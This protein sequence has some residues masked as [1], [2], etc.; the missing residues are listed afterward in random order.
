MYAGEGMLLWGTATE[1]KSMEE[2]KEG[3]S[4]ERHILCPVPRGNRKS[5]KWITS[6]SWYSSCRL[7]R[8]QCCLMLHQMCG[9]LTWNVALHQC[10]HWICSATERLCTQKRLT[11][12][13][14]QYPIM[15]LLCNVKKIVFRSHRVS[16]A[17]ALTVQYRQLKNAAGTSLV[18]TSCQRA[19]SLA[20]SQMSK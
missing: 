9:E 12:L 17:R 10:V 1:H 15:Y 18:Y 13:T 16:E 4:S 19:S 8:G 2:Y 5:N 3:M 11:E 7:N 14:A 20:S 6:M